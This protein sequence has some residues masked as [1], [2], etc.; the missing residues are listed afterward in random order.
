MANPR[1]LKKLFNKSIKMR[2]QNQEYTAV[3]YKM[4]EKFAGKEISNA[5]AYKMILVMKTMIRRHI[6]FGN[7][8]GSNDEFI[9]LLLK[10]VQA[11]VED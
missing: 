5:T 9:D 11:L 10:I 3:V 1:D 7:I 8:F 2:E 4:M 6:V